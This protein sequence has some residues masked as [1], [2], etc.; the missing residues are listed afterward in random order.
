MKDVPLTPLH[1]RVLDFIRREGLAPKG[2][3]VVTAL[4]GGGDSVALLLLLR[5]LAPHA[6]YTLAGSR[7]SEPPASSS[8]CGG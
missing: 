3:R 8:R 6:G 2:S 4:S 5:D 1:D 7:P